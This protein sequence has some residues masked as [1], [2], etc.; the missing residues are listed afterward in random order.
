MTVTFDTSVLL[1]WYQAKAGQAS[2]SAAANGSATSAS[3]AAIPT[4]PWN[5]GPAAQPKDSALVTS[6]L[7]GHAFV[8]EKAAKL[9]VP[10]ANADYKKL[11]A[12]NQALSTLEALANA[13]NSSTTPSFQLPSIQ[14]AFARGMSEIQAYVNTSKFSEFRLTNG[15]ATGSDTSVVASP[16]P[17]SADSYTTPVL[18]SGSADAAVTAFAGTVQF[19]ANIKKASGTV[20]TVSFDLSEMGTTPRTMNS[21]AAYMN[22]KLAAAGVGTKVSVSKTDV[23]AQTISVNGQKVE[24]SPAQTDLAFNLTGLSSETVSF[25]APTT[26]PAVYVAQTAGDPNPDGNAATAD[27]D[28]QQEMLK[29]EAGSGADA[30]RRPNDAT[31]AAGQVFSQKLPDGITTVH[32]TTTGADGSVYVVADGSGTVDGQPIKGS[33]DAVLLK[34]DSGGNLVYTQTL[35]AGVSASGAS[36]SVSADGKVAIAGSITGALDNGDAGADPKTADSFVTVFDAHGQELWSD[37]QGGLGADQAQAVAFDATGNVYVAGK[38]QGTI[39]GGSAVGGWDSYLRAYSAT[40]VVQSTQEFGSTSDDSVGAIA[41]NGSTVYVAGQDGGAA[42]V[43]SFDVTNPKQMALTGLRNLGSLGGG[44]V[45]A[46]GFDGSGNLLIGGSTGANLNVATTT[47]ARGGGLD[48]FGLRL[49][50]NL[51]STATDAVAYYGGSGADRTTAATVAN[52]QV[53]L[54][55]VTST[56]LPGLTAVGKQD[57]YVAG[58]DVGAGAVTYSQ[59][60]TAKDQMD[61][62]EAIAVDA[63]GGSALDRLGL[64]KGTVQVGLAT[65]AS[66]PATGST[67]P[68]LSTFTALRA[69]DQFQLRMGSSSTATTIII[70]ANETMNSLADKIRL[71]GL[72]EIDVQTL[73]NGTGKTLQLKPANDRTTFELRSG[74]AGRDALAALGIKP[75]LVRNT[76]VDPKKG[77]LPA[78]KGTQTYGLRFTAPLDLN[79]KAD[80]KAALDGVTNAITT[81]R[82]IYADLKQAATPPSQQQ[83]QGSVPAY[84]QTRIADYQAA[85]DRLTAGSSDSSSSG[86]SLASLFG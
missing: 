5:A 4:A 82:A 86:S 75:G 45:E 58:L 39:G 3:A 10:T 27:S 83:Q 20:V 1:S 73:S 51:A 11:F 29:L 26:N 9:D 61:A 85:L 72:F 34:Y 55:G 76:I 49:S 24:I 40:G 69:G 28:Q 2:V 62:P 71:A 6:A 50:A 74:P 25:A 12:L 80:I 19:S 81:V 66:N 38:A 17:S 46:V 77:V 22:T 36:L 70:G 64:P 47:A 18:A 42:T 13:A 59:R 23:A 78:D 67:D 16:D 43:R 65:I 7:A 54:T 15:I 8:D 84:M 53:W 56:D 41:V 48:G 37:R 60:F 68:L 14:S 63:T 30:A 33:Q 44:A 57:G 79:S 21:V 35:G 32:A 31:Y 52:G